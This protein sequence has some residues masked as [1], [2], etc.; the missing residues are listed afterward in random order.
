MINFESFIR[1]IKQIALTPDEQTRIQNNLSRFITHYALREPATLR[2]EKPQ[3]VT[4]MQNRFIPAL[5]SPRPLAFALVLAILFGGGI[6]FGSQQALPG[7]VLYPIKIA[8]ETIH[9]SLT[10]DAKHRANLETE[11]AIKRLGEAEKLAAKNELTPDIKQKI[12][13]NF[14]VHVKSVANRIQKFEDEKNI[15]DASEVASNFENSI[16]VHSRIL[17]ALKPKV[18]PSAAREATTSVATTTNAQDTASEIHSRAERL[19]TEL[20]G[21]LKT[22]A[23]NEPNIQTSA[24]SKMR[25]AATAI[26]KAEQYIQKAEAK[27]GTETT[28]EAR[29]RLHMANDSFIKGE[30]QLNAHAYADAF[31]LFEDAIQEAKQ[32]QFL[33][34]T[35]IEATAGAPIKMKKDLPGKSAPADNKESDGENTSG[36]THTDFQGNLR[37]KLEF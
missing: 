17:D 29:V 10:V 16:D 18:E 25:T 31:V 4:A 22:E 2:R 8:G 23:E 36:S 15:G 21:K 26:K 37:A 1:I 11:L 14:D 35:G 34:K 9:A 12:E 3:G 6:A 7:D 27:F 24:E 32:A 19:R 30:T 28:A 20:N 5:F 33:T 13:E